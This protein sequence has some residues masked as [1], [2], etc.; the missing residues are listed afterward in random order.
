MESVH[1][2]RITEFDIHLFKEGKHYNLYDKLGSHPMTHDGVEGTYFALWAPNAER[3]SVVGDFNNWDRGSHTMQPRWDGSG[4]WETFLPGVNHGT[5]YK[6]FI[7]SRFNGYEAEKGDPFAVHWEKPPQT[8]S[9]VWDRSYNWTDGQWLDERKKKMG[10][11]RPMAVYE[12]HIGSWKRKGERGEQFLNYRELADELCSY[13]KDMGYTHVEFLPVMEHP[14]YG[15]WGYQCTGYFAPSSR[16]GTPQDFMYLVDRLHNEN[17]GVIL[18]WV[19]SHFPNDLHGLHYFD[20]T[21]LFEHEDPRQGYHPD[22]NSYIF[23]YSRNEVRSFLISSAMFWLRECHADGLRVDAVAS[24][25]YLDYS[26]KEGEWIPN[27]YGG[28]ENLDAINFLK[29]FNNA[30]DAEFPDVHTIAEESTAWPMVSRPTQIGGL[31]FE[32]KWM[33][34]WMHDTLDYMSKDPIYRKYH[35]GE[36]TFSLMYAFTENFMLPLS[37]DEVVHGKG[38]LI[39]KMPGD[40]WQRFANLRALYSY[41]YVHP[42]T[43]L[44]FMGGEFGQTQEWRHDQSLDWHLCEYEPHQKMQNLVRKLNELYHSEPA[45]YERQFQPEG[46]EWIDIND[47]QN[48]VI[49]LLRKGHQEQNNLYVVINFTPAVHE[50][51]RI[52]VPHKGY[53]REIFNSDDL[54]FGGS[55]V[56]NQ[57]QLETLPIPMHGRAR[58]VNLTLPPLGMSILKYEEH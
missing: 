28:R 10:E 16:Y 57:G 6:Y 21:H 11:D 58:S 3:V 46:F 39:D 48:S 41:M 12:M 55:G 35:Q 45:L 17:I 47:Y 22:W 56:L 19:P 27:E 31:G 44:L 23:N 24:M 7:R 13:L 49:S 4:I 43:K 9:V 40:E 14:F 20:G 42:G 37:H 1:P 25:L 54:E 34:G 52:G 8:A 33:M 50:N 2:T 26:R 53:L 15:S 18:D 38:P 29:E 51:Y 5:R 36:I 32:M 30:V